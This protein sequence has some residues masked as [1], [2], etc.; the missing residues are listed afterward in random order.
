MFVLHKI[1]F[2][3]VSYHYR[4]KTLLLRIS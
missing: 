2:P 3:Y 1:L 4:I